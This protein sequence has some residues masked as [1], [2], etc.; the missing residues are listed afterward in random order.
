MAPAMGD[1]GMVIRTKKFKEGKK[2]VNYAL[3]KY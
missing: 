3:E 1:Y 2:I